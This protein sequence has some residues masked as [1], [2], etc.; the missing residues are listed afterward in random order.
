MALVVGN[1][2]VKYWAEES[3][4]RLRVTCLPG[5]TLDKLLCAAVEGNRVSDSV[6][7]IQSGIPDLQLK[8]KHS[9]LP[10]RLV[11]YER[12]LREVH[13]TLPKAVIL[14]IYPP[15]NSTQQDCHI[16]ENINTLITELNVRGTPNTVSRVFHRDHEGY[17]RV[18]S[19]RLADGI[20]PRRCESTRMV[21]RILD[22]VLPGLHRGRGVSNAPATVTSAIEVSAPVS[23]QDQQPLVAMRQPTS[24]AVMVTIEEPLSASEQVGRLLEEKSRRLAE[25]KLEY[26]QRKKALEEECVTSIQLILDAHMGGVASMVTAAGIPERR[27]DSDRGSSNLR[28]KTPYAYRSSASTSEKSPS[29]LRGRISKGT[30]RSTRVTGPSSPPPG[31]EGFVVLD[32]WSMGSRDVRENVPRRVDFC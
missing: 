14:M 22:F 28:H 10:E 17:F 32:E 9:I 25:L 23:Q 19:R 16:Y 21:G 7:Y 15:L 30:S 18:E 11:L 13:K 8:G 3:E 4:G 6:I 20:H 2:L 24:P 31:E 12:R 29:D 26:K 1:S 5:A 27:L